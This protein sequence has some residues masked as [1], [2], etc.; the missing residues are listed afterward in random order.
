MFSLQELND[1]RLCSRNQYDA[2]V[3][4]ST[5]QPPL[6]RDVH[7][8]RHLNGVAGAGQ[9]A[10]L[11]NDARW[12]R[13]ELIKGLL[14]TDAGRHLE[15][16]E[17]TEV[18]WDMSMFLCWFRNSLLAL[19]ARLRVDTRGQYVYSTE[20]TQQRATLNWLRQKMPKTPI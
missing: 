18:K 20:Y 2:A 3:L 7:A 14:E 12:R 4:S 5:H 10:Q 8:G 13:H 9:D 15:L 17:G 11:V 6:R 1:G 16:W 19:H